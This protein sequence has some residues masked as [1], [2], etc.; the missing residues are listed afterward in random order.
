[1]AALLRRFFH[2]RRSDRAAAAVALYAE[3]ELSGWVCMPP[4]AAKTGDNRFAG[5][6]AETDGLLARFYFSQEC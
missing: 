6:P 4:E 1:M 2:R 3:A 5:Q